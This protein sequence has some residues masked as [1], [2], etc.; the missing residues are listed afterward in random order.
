MELYTWPEPM[1]IIADEWKSTRNA[2]SEIRNNEASQL[3]QNETER[4]A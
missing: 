4:K 2:S 1:I 3:Y